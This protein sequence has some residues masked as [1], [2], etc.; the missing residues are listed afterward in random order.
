M[1]TVTHKGMQ[2]R[3]YATGGP[4]SAFGLAKSLLANRDDQIMGVV[5]KATGPAP[6][7]KP[8]P[9]AIPPKPK[10]LGLGVKAPVTA[11]VNTSAQDAR[12]AQAR[13]EIERL[14]ASG[15]LQRAG[16]LEDTLKGYAKGGK[17]PGKGN[18]DTVP[19]MLTPGEFVM[20]KSAVQKHGMAKMKAM[21]SGGMK[22]R[23]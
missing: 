17:V 22:R 3:A 9:V 13:V 11:T 6:V 7:A 23:S 19:A 18:K 21:N 5:N 10:T 14:K 15:N 20:K 8:A 12:N 4:V 1:N 16:E 2:R